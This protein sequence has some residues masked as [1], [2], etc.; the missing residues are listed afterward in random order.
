MKFPDVFLSVTECIKF[1]PMNNHFACCPPISEFV[2]RE[3]KFHKWVSKI[4]IGLKYTYSTVNKIRAERDGSDKFST[5][6]KIGTETDGSEGDGLF[7][8]ISTERDGSTS[9]IDGT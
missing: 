2:L 5:V 9:I 6:S 3:N 8:K 7:D 1:T 4:K